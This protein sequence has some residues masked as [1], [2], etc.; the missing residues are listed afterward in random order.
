MK[1]VFEFNKASQI[2]NYDYC[3]DIPI[4]GT[5]L[6]GK[7]VKK[8]PDAKNANQIENVSMIFSEFDKEEDALKFLEKLSS[9]FNTDVKL[10]L[11][12]KIYIAKRSVSISK[13]PSTNNN[14]SN[15]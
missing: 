8:N 12:D 3:N 11:D 7:K 5:F 10:N 1:A 2:T 14:L 13:E 4:S 15:N 9:D 6:V